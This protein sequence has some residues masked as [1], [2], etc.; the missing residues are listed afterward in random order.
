MRIKFLALIIALSFLITN[1][2][3]ASF[4]D[5]PEYWI[6]KVK[7]EN[8]R[9]TLNDSDPAFLDFWDS[10][11]LMSSGNFNL[12][13][14]DISN[15]VVEKKSFGLSEG[16]NLIGIPSYLNL[17]KLIIADTNGTILF[18]YDFPFYARTCNE[19]NKCEDGEENLC[20]LDCKYADN[21]NYPLTPNKNEI[22]KN[23]PQPLETPMATLT[24]ETIKNQ[25]KNYLIV[26]GVG[27][28]FLLI[29]FGIIYL[30]K[31]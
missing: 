1:D 22:Q 21:S 2:S 24:P 10:P 16:E 26:L 5:T 4:T 18:F 8:N 27:I 12:E 28:T 3:F 6:L 15:R 29:I 30:K 23:P 20:P 13:I 11:P 31:R 9:I 19:N 7:F 17:Q 14:L 25:F